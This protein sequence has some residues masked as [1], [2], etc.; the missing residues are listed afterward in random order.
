M[1]VGDKIYN[2]YKKCYIILEYGDVLC[3][4]CKGFG[5]VYKENN[6]DIQ[7]IFLKCN[8]CQGDGKFTWTEDILGK[9]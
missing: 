1:D 8:E 9:K 2:K 7:K 3:K 6:F 5:V 4:K